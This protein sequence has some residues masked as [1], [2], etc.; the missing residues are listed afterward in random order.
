MTPSR[1]WLGSFCLPPSLLSFRSLFFRLE[2]L[3]AAWTDRRQ[4]RVRDARLCRRCPRIPTVLYLSPF[5]QATGSH[6]TDLLRMRDLRVSCSDGCSERDSLP[7]TDRLRQLF[8]QLISRSHPALLA[9]QNS[10]PPL[11]AWKFEHRSLS[12]WRR[13]GALEKVVLSL[14][15]CRQCS[16][17]SGSEYCWWEWTQVV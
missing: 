9:S 6:K 17:W 10:S 5:H 1:E 15:H 7:Q 2:H 8:M 11:P 14:I 3:M 4:S 13:H 12:A 16:R